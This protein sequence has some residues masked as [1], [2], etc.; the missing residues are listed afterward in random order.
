MFYRPRFKS[1]SLLTFRTCFMPFGDQLLQK[2]GPPTSKVVATV[3]SGGSQRPF[4]ACALFE[5]ETIARARIVVRIRV[6]GSGSEKLP[7][8][9]C[10]SW[11]QLRMFH[12]NVQTNG[13]SPCQ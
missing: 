6:H 2:K 4:R 5:Q 10:L 9:G 3:V 7:R 12:N 13:K 1:R 8:N 11:F